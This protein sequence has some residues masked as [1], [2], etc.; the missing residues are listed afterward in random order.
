MLRTTIVAAGDGAPQSPTG[1]CYYLL[2][3]AIA[4]VLLLI[5]LVAAVWRFMDWAVS[6]SHCLESSAP[7]SVSAV[8]AAAKDAAVALSPTPSTRHAS[9][10]AAAAS[11]VE[12]PCP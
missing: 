4:T 12:C 6:P 8:A 9:R 1:C 11:P 7:P 10:I 5:V 3:H 2:A